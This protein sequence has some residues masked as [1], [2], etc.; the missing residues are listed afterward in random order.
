MVGSQL[1]ALLEN[2]VRRDGQIRN[3][4]FGVADGDTGFTWS[5]AVGFADPEGRRAMQPETP[6]FIASVTKMYTTAAILLLQERGQLHLDDPISQYLPGELI[7]GIHRY[8]GQ[9]YTHQLTI[10]HLISH[11]SGLADFSLDRPRQ[12]QSLMKQLWTEGDRA[13]TLADVLRLVREDLSPKFPPAVPDPQTGRFTP[14]KA[15]YSD[16]NFQLLGAIIEAVTARPLHEVYEAFFFRPLDLT[17]TYL[18]GHPW[19]VLSSEPAAFFYQE[20]A[21]RLPLAMQ[22]VSAQGGIV[23]TVADSLRFLR[24]LTQGELFRRPATFQA[25]QQWNKIFFPFQYGYGLMRFKLPRLLS[26]FAPAPELVGHSGSTG[27][28]LY[29]CQELNLYL[30]GTINHTQ[31]PRAPFPLMLRA[32]EIIRKGRRAVS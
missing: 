14:A 21:L 6:Y 32:I 12:G 30:A 11:T 7:T 23:S 10:R 31:R 19:R 4:V 2:L 5:G 15:H 8:K 27:S 25:M 29:V 1:Q 26:P 24:A 18:F 9:D 16:T 20:R 13:F 3:A 22:S 17:N 28:F